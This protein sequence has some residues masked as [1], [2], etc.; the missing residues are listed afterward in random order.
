MRL[1]IY[2]IVIVNYFLHH[3]LLLRLVR[4]SPVVVIDFELL[5]IGTA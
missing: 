1:G 3:F 2:S 4:D 5:P